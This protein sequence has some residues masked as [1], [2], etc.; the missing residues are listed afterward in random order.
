MFVSN[1]GELI[2]SDFVCNCGRVLTSAKLKPCITFL[3]F[4]SSRCET[5]VL[6]SVTTIGEE[7]SELVKEVG[8]SK[9]N[10]FKRSASDN[11][12]FEVF[13]EGEEK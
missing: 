9:V 3:L 8:I 5:S 1:S 6:T 10:E 2:V 13:W 7:E 4:P 12:F 11:S